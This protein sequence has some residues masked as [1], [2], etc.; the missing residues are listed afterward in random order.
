MTRPLWGLRRGS[1]QRRIWLTED[2]WRRRRWKSR[3]L[4]SV[5]RHFLRDSLW[6][7]RS[8]RHARTTRLSD[9]LSAG[10]A[11]YLP[12]LEFLVFLGL[13]EK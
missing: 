6:R 11:G 12:T 7:G 9:V 3:T 2:G 13:M 10:R 1:I 8:V 5:A 4:T